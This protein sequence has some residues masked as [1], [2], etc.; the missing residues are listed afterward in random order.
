M[1]STSEGLGS[2]SKH[3]MQHNGQ[4][5]KNLLRPDGRRVHVAASPEEHATLHKTLA[6][7]EPDANFNICLHGSPEHLEAVRVRALERVPDQRLMHGRRYTPT[8]SR[9]A[10]SFVRRTPM[11]TKNLRTSTSSWKPWLTS[12]TTLPNKKC[13]WMQIS[14][15]SDMMRI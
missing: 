15:S 1:A 13:H 11:S 14:Q 10:M 4:R 6:E 2:K 7:V 5:L 12:C 8:T 3:G 9:N